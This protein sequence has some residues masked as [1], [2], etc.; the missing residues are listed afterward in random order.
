[1]WSNLRMAWCFDVRK[2][3]IWGVVS[4]N[5]C[6]SRWIL[7]RVPDSQYIPY[8]QSCVL[9]LNSSPLQTMNLQDSLPLLSLY[10]LLLSKSLTMSWPRLTTPAKIISSSLQIRLRSEP[11]GVYFVLVLPDPP[12]SSCTLFVVQSFRI[13]LGLPR[14]NE[15]YRYSLRHYIVWG[16]FV[17]NTISGIRIM[18]ECPQQWDPP[19]F[20]PFS[21]ASSGCMDSCSKIE[22]CGLASSIAA[23]TQRHGELLL[24]Y[25]ISD[26]WFSWRRHCL[27][28]IL[29]LSFFNFSNVFI[30]IH[31]NAAITP[32]GI[33]FV[34]HFIAAQ[35][36]GAWVYGR[37][38]SALRLTHFE[39]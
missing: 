9:I 32:E 16:S 10:G 33:W 29:R 14:N 18:C 24:A 35:S 8:R 37:L 4:L 20:Q 22:I 6:Q 26:L 5:L 11:A 19:S 36:R 39:D 7:Q 17:S 25:P 12:S 13:S 38:S 15:G 23:L 1:M 21:H 2:H 27:Y 30:D 28:S 34:T 3:Q 31:W